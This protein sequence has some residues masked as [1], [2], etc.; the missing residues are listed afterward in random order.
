MPIFKRIECS[1]G[2]Q[3]MITLGA[4]EPVECLCELDYDPRTGQA[5]PVWE[6]FE[7]SSGQDPS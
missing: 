4:R 1:C 7:L 5:L 3:F 6:G 2:H